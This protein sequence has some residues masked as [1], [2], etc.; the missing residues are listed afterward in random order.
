MKSLLLF[1]FISLT[2][3]S[4]AQALESLELAQAWVNTRFTGCDPAIVDIV[5]I[6][7]VM[8]L[9][10]ARKGVCDGVNLKDLSNEKTQTCFKDLNK[11]LQIFIDKSMVRTADYGCKEN[12]KFADY[13]NGDNKAI[14]AKEEVVSVSIACSPVNAKEGFKIYSSNGK[15]VCV[16]EYDCGRYKS[17]FRFGL[18]EP[19][20]P[21][22]YVFRCLAVNSV[23]SDCDKMNLYE[24]EGKEVSYSSLKA[25]GLYKSEPT[26]VRASKGTGAN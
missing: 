7:N 8:T 18:S 21:G 17:K 1:P 23:Q 24:C 11:A 22:N 26:P 5:N 12:P 9:N 3:L 16:R 19:L 20:E 15:N 2:F 25:F 10:G 14:K 6:K 4:N 13:I